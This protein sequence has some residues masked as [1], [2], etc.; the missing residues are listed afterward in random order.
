M[1]ENEMLIHL[2]EIRKRGMT[3]GTRKLLMQIAE[4]AERLE[5]GLVKSGDAVEA[6]KYYMVRKQCELWLD[7]SEG[8]KS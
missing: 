2:S 4:V 8:D 5:K 3:D 1:K 6:H 7:E